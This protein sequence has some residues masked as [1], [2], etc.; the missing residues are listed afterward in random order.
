[1]SCHRICLR[2]WP[3]FFAGTLL[4]SAVPF[5]DPSD[6]P[7]P[8][9]KHNIPLETTQMGEIVR[10]L[11]GLADSVGAD[12]PEE[13]RAIA[14]IFALSEVLD[15][16]SRGFARLK[17]ELPGRNFR[18]E[19]AFER[20]RGKVRKIWEMIA[21]L[22]TQNAG[23][24][25]QAL[26]ACLKDIMAVMNPEHPRVEELRKIGEIGEWDSWVMPVAAFAPKDKQM[27][28]DDLNS[29]PD[30]WGQKPE[31]PDEPTM[32]RLKEAS[33][34][35][36]LWVPSGDGPNQ[37]PVAKL[38]DLKM[39]ARIREK[40][41]S[42]DDEEESDF[43]SFHVSIGAWE[44]S[45]H[46][47]R[48]SRLVERILKN[49][50]SNLP[51]GLYIEIRHPALERSLETKQSHA[52]SAVSAVL[53]VSSLTG[54]QQSGVILGVMDADGNFSSSRDDWPKLAALK[55]AEGLRIIVPS[56]AE[57]Y[58]AAYLAMENPDF[59][60]KN[61]VYTASHLD[62]VLEFSASPLTPELQLLS[63]RFG[64]VR[65]KKGNQETG[66][67]LA[68]SLI[69]QRLVA[70][71]KEEPRH[72]SAKLLALQAVGK[73]PVSVSRQVLS[74]DMRLSLLPLG[75]LL[76]REHI[77]PRGDGIGDLY[78][79]C[80]LGVEQA[81]QYASRDDQD[82][83]DEANDVLA[84][85]R[86]LDRAIRSKRGEYWEA[87]RDVGVAKR[88]LGKAARDFHDFVTEILQGESED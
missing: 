57:D 85:V 25:G 65:D 35:A 54:K 34:P 73:R 63:D 69:R 88:E 3:A 8:F 14:Q 24:D 38:E 32:V 60:L 72:L 23:I 52:L 64:E 50:F 10:G 22:E 44:D 13:R 15:P 45:P 81:A 71:H 31:N 84:H 66:F 51:E 26:A 55:E 58:V 74:S 1:M 33:L 40:P 11:L 5:E 67:Y 70:L 68:N 28:P 53:A 18:G 48:L 4:L 20:V 2:V 46:T 86:A 9:R 87:E 17:S 21:W 39:K 12:S 56:E 27:P 42:E 6:G 80:R 82:V 79:K 47:D 76:R 59:L 37:Y 62:E 16:D 36:I 77:S 83:V 78:E 29:K 19:T 49:R 41:E 61:E 7:V 75:G 30:D 43:D